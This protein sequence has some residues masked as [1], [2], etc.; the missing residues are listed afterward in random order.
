M[1]R[2]QQRDF[3]SDVASQNARE[4]ADVTIN[5]LRT[6]AA[7]DTTSEHL[8][9]AIPSACKHELQGQT[10]FR[11]PEDMDPLQA[12]R[13]ENSW[14]MASLLRE[15]ETA[16]LEGE[17]DEQAIERI[18]D[19]IS[20]LAPLDEIRLQQGWYGSINER[21]G[22]TL[23]DLAFPDYDSGEEGQEE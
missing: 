3:E 8:L 4:A 5:T 14:Y 21:K 18:N 2:E 20:R 13:Y 15:I 10:A 11:I 23:E 9:D 19:R 6:L 12:K 22:I 16:R 7:S 1:D 17:S